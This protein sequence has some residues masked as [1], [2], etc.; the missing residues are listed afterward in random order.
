M[1]TPQLHQKIEDLRNRTKPRSHQTEKFISQLKDEDIEILN[2]QMDRQTV[3]IWI[4]CRSQAAL[5][6]IQRLYESNQL[7]E[8]FLENIQSS[9][10]NLISIDSIQFNKTIGKFT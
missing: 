10:L 1:E 2:S 9:T 5:D 7:K 6:Y 8:I 4:W 3:V